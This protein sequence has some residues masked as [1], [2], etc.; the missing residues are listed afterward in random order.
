MEKRL[1][2]LD[3]YRGLVLALMMGEALHFCGVAAAFPASALWAFLCHHQDHVALGRRFAPRPD[4]AGLLVPGGSGAAVLARRPGPPRREPGPD[5]GP[6]L[7]ARADADR[8]GDRLCARSAARKPYFTFED[9]LTQIG[10]GYGFLFLLALRP[11]RDQWLALALILVA[12]WAAFALYPVP[13][14]DFDWRR[15][16]FPRTGRT[17]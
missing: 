1:A 13:G 15:W 4:P 12:F 11:R 17:S 5:G 8:P 14:P 16:A 3:A 9:T 7:P 2:S 6:R 10:L